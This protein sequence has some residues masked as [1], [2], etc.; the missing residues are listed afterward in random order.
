MNPATKR[1][2]QFPYRKIEDLEAE[3][4]QHEAAM[5][6]L[7]ATLA[8]GE[9]YRDAERVKLTMRAFEDEKAQLARL[10]EHWVEADELN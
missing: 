4:A 6:Q 10:Y 2:R 1:K 3:I 7:E 9:L 8:D 5:K